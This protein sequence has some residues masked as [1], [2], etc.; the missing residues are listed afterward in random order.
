LRGPLQKAVLLS[1]LAALVYAVPYAVP[2]K[3]VVS[4]SYVVN[5]S[6][7]TAVLLFL[8]GMLLFCVLTAGELARSET[9]DSTLSLKSLLLAE[10]FVLTL[11]GLRLWGE[12]LGSEA[13]YVLHR[14]QML[15]AGRHLYTETDYLYGPALIM[16]GVWLSR[17]LRL[18]IVAGYLTSYVLLL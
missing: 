1:G 15:V 4:V 14:Q 5:F 12:G 18:S 8:G 16:P 7:R 2:V 10:A 6:N 17:L 11:G 13:Q 9:R 3:P